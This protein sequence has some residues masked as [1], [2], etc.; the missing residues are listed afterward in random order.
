MYSV[1]NQTSPSF[2]CFKLKIP[3]SEYAAK[4]GT[5]ALEKLNF[6]RKAVEDCKYWHIIFDSEG[7]KIQS[8]ATSKVYEIDQNPKRPRFS[9]FHIRTK[10]KEHQISGKITSF[11]VDLGSP[12]EAKALYKNIV[13]ATGLDKFILIVKALNNQVVKRNLSRKVHA[14]GVE[15]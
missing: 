8:A 3:Y 11:R 7:Y 2:G 1:N 10:N 4:E 9:S 15:N 13:S 12:E 5:E 14:A 6:A